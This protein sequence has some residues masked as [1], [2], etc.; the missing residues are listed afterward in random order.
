MQDRERAV[1]RRRGSV[2]RGEEGLRQARGTLEQ[3][4]ALRIRELHNGGL[5]QLPH[6]A[7]REVALELARSRSQT[8]EARLGRG[9]GGRPEQGRLPEP[10]SRLD[11]EGP[12]AALPRLS[13]CV[14][15]LGELTLAL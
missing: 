11:E 3:T 14:A 15:E 10:R 1:G 7:V 4:L 5:E 2:G 6:A 9:L 8:G 13:Q 12:A